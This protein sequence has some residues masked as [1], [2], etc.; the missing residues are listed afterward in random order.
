[1][2][3]RTEQ[4][5]KAHGLALIKLFNLPENTD[6]V[7]LCRKLRRIENKGRMAA[8]RWANG[9]IDE[10]VYFFTEKKLWEILE[11]IFPKNSY[12]FISLGDVFFDSDP[13]GYFLKIRKDKSKEFPYRDWG[14]YGI[15]A[16]DLN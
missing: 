11:S 6:P 9:E 5:V 16:P 2:N 7:A 14:G 1:M 10:E 13:R 12:P 8:E 15:I 3:P 4:R